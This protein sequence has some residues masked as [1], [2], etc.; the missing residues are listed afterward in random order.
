LELE[1]ADELLGTKTAKEKRLQQIENII[2]SK[3]IELQNPPKTECRKRQKIVCRLNLGYG[4]ASGF[5][6]ILWCLIYSYY[7]NKT[8]FLN[9][10]NNYYFSATNSKDKHFE[11]WERFLKPL[12]STCDYRKFSHQKLEEVPIGNSVV[13]RRLMNKLPKLFGYDLIDLVDSPIAWFHSQFTG[14]IMR[15][16]KRLVKHLEKFKISIGYSHPIVGVQVR[17]SDKLLD[18]AVYHPLSDYMIYVKD[19][20]E[21]LELS[22]KVNRKLVYVASDDPKVLPQFIQE[23]PEY[24]FIGNTEGAEIAS[25]E[26]GS[27]ASLWGLLTDIYL[28]SETDFIVCTFSSAVSLRNKDLT[29]I[30]FFWIF[31]MIQKNL[32]K[33]LSIVLS[34]NAILKRRRIV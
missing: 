30:A 19:Y 8:M 34:I 10:E 17:R 7:N 5:H 12:S 31:K 29:R 11:G 33:G 32:F 13:H 3:I 21:K 18:E 4:L 28:L 27:N 16:Q 15:P 23:Y 2:G 26:R 9:K 6:E 22:Q 24:S 20:F 14:Y 25:N 1:K